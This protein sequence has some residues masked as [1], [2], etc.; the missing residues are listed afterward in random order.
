VTA[1]PLERPKELSEKALLTD[2]ETAEYEHEIADRQ[3]KAEARPHTGYAASVWFETGHKL[4]ENR[5]SLLVEPP[6]GHLPP[7]TPEAQ[8]IAEQ[9]AQARKLRPADGPEDRGP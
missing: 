6:G 5:T 7:L 2:A 3:A 9:E 8:K 1:T 4:S